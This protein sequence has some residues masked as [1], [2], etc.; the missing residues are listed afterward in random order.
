[1]RNKIKYKQKKLKK[2]KVQT[3]KSKKKLSTNRIAD[4]T[5]FAFVLS[6]TTNVEKGTKKVTRWTLV[7]NCKCDIKVREN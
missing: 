4:G 2:S 5:L 7:I 1:M 3:E 6:L